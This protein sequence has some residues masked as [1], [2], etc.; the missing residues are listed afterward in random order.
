MKKRW[1]S[2]SLK[3]RITL[4]TNL[5]KAPKACVE[6]VIIH[7]L[8]HLVYHNHSNKFLAL[9]NKEMP[10]WEKWRNKLEEFAE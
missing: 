2:C 9:L 3:G 4:N 7:E 6:Y 1:G 8:C 10:D 5:I